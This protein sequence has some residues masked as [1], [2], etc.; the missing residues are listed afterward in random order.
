MSEKLKLVKPGI[1]LLLD[2]VAI[3]T[4][5]MGLTKYDQFIK[6]I[7][8]MVSGTLASFSSSLL[9]NFYDRDID[10][11]MKRTNWRSKFSWD[12]SYITAILVMLLSSL[13]IS[14]IFLNLITM[15]WIFAGFLAYAVLYTMILKRNTAWNIV[16]GGIAGSFPALAGWS[17]VNSPVSFESLY[18]AILVFIWTPTHFWSLALKYKEDYKKVG[19]PMM[20]SIMS[21]N[22]S[23]RLILINT[24]ILTAYTIIPLLYNGFPLIFRLFILP[25]SFYLLYKALNLLYTNRENTDSAAIKTFLASNYF[26][27]G[28]LFLLIAG[29]ILH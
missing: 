3:S 15:I 21:L 26:L 13:L 9:N 29:M 22:K 10:R 24:A 20:P 4:F 18:I 25:L 11:N 27:T 12:L 1:T 8:L 17:S 23:K 19:I 6:I 7:P 16:I 14:Y 5:L 28:A 2:L